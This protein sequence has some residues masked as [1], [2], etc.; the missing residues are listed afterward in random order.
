MT[1]ENE[2]PKK[3]PEMRMYDDTPVRTPPKSANTARMAIQKYWRDVEL[4]RSNS[5][6]NET[7]AR[8]KY[9]DLFKGR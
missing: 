7:H 8:K 4:Q 1:D 3:I 9:P 5:H 6:P 2:P